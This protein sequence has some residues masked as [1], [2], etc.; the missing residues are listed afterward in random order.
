MKS[1]FI[2]DNGDYFESK[3]EFVK[4]YKELYFSG[5]RFSKAHSR[6]AEES[7]EQY[8]IYD[9]YAY[10]AICAIKGDFSNGYSIAINKPNEIDS[11]LLGNSFRFDDPRT[12]IGNE[13]VQLKLNA[14]NATD[15]SV[16]RIEEVYNKYLDDLKEVFGDA[17]NSRDVDQALWVY[18]HLFA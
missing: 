3:E 1:S 9:Q 13:F 10:R 2:K 5:S 17:F 11:E 16:K 14:P 6:I 4:Y 7:G 8:P 15:M 18:G 12:L